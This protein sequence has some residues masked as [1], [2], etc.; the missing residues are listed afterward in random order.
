MMRYRISAVGT[1]SIGPYDLLPA[2]IRY[3]PCFATRLGGA[4]GGKERY[5]CVSKEIGPPGP[6]SETLWYDPLR[7]PSRHSL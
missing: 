6:A 3:H 2:A 1:R 7:D 5:V 4:S